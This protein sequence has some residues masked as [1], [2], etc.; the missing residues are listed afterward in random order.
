MEDSADHY[1]PKTWENT[2]ITSYRPI[3]LLPVLSTVLEKLF[4]KCLRP[5]IRL[6]GKAWNHQR[7]TF[8]NKICNTIKFINSARLLAK[9][10]IKGYCIKLQNHFYITFMR[11]LKLLNREVLFNETR[12]IH[13]FI[14]C[15]LRLVL[16]LPF[17][18]NLPATTKMEVTRTYTICI[19]EN[20][21]AI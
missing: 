7:N 11:L 2:D 4:L 14:L 21:N 16:Y 17:T 13:K 19:E 6:Q 1:D 10:S 18:A 9:C 8:I 15:M 20:L 12:W 3:S 5:Q